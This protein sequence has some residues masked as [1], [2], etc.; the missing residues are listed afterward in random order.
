MDKF[1]NIL[2]LRNSQEWIEFDRYCNTGFLEQIDFFRYEDMHTNFLASLLKED[3]V[4][5]LGTK[6]LKLFIELLKVKDKNHLENKLKQDLLSNYSVS[7][8]EVLTQESI[9]VGRIDL[10]I[11]FNIENEKYNIIFENKLFSEESSEG[12]TKRYKEYFDNHFSND[13]NIYVFLSLD[14]NLEISAGNDYIR[15]DYQELISYVLEPCSYLEANSLASISVEEYLKGFTY[16]CEFGYMPITSTLRKLSVAIYNNY[17][18]ELINILNGKQ[19]E[20]NEFYSN[21]I[22]Q[23]KILFTV[24]EKEVTTKKNLKDK[25]NRIVLGKVGKFR[26]KDNDE[27][28]DYGCREQTK[29]VRDILKDL[30]DNGYLKTIEDLDELKF[31]DNSSWKPAITEEQYKAVGNRQSNYSKDNDLI[32]ES[33]TLYYSYPVSNE[34]LKGFVECVIKKYPNYKKLIEVC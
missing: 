10:L 12:Q 4:F 25:I 8:I 24:L 13:N 27:Y 29:M 20:Y 3:N 6:P 11:K 28:T 19:G 14:N 32:V 9:D 22:K 21:N 2:K 15:I 23:F 18:E 16:L 33:K 31:S 26:K 1:E 5:G 30:I 17:S 7:N 34:E